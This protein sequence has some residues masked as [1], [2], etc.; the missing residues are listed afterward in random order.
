MVALK[1]RNEMLVIHKYNII[2]QKSTL[3]GW[4]SL[5]VNIIMMLCELFLFSFTK[6]LPRVVIIALKWQGL[7]R[8]NRALHAHQTLIMITRCG[9]VL[10]KP[11]VLSVAIATHS[12]VWWGCRCERRVERI[13]CRVDPHVGTV[14][15]D[16]RSFLTCEMVHALSFIFIVLTWLT[17]HYVSLSNYS[18][19]SWNEVWSRDLVFK[20]TGVVSCAQTRSLANVSLWAPRYVKTD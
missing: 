2:K 1:V 11:E 20:K 6:H 7:G 3:L 5:T 10:V 4:I 8:T 18:E 15:L 13:R 19:L 12:M 9:S 16:Y 14:N 17:T